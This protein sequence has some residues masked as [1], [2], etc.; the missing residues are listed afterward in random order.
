MIEV[1][2]HAATD[3]TGF[4]LLGHLR[5]MT[6]ASGLEAIVEF[7]RVPIIAAAEGYA[8][9]G[10]VPGGTHANFRFL[11]EHVTLEVDKTNQLLACDAQTSGGLLI[12]VSES[13]AAELIRAL[14][15]RGTPA[16]ACIGRLVEGTPGRARVV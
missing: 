7:S 3:V 6:L 12:A 9:E 4:G 1:G 11:S 14:E 10:I 5:N 16:A 2:V 15:N 8:A 13:K